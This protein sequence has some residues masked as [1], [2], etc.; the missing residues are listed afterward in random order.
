[1][2]PHVAIAIDRL[3]DRDLRERVS[4]GDF[5]PLADL[6]LTPEEKVLLLAGYQVAAA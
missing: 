2:A 1:M 5:A 3:E 6:D 4:R